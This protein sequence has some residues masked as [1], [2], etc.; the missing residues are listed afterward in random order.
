MSLALR[1]QQRRWFRVHNA[2]HLKT[3]GKP[4]SCASLSAQCSCLVLPCR[5]KLLHLRGQHAF[6]DLASPA[7]WSVS[8]RTLA[9]LHCS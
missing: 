9:A 3:E 6:L 4:L 1:K 7:C 8:G 2:L 5:P